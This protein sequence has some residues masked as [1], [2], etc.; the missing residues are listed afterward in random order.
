MTQTL[1]WENKRH[2]ENINFAH[3]RLQSLQD[4]LQELSQ[5]KGYIISYIDILFI[6]IHIIQC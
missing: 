1:Q 5:E 2:D 6:H 3:K 4:E